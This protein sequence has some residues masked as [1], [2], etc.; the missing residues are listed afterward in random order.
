MERQ[1]A[2]WKTVHTIEGENDLV[3]QIQR[4]GDYKPRYSFKIGRY[5][6]GR[7]GDRYVGAYAPVWINAVE[8]IVADRTP[9]KLAA[10]AVDWIEGDAAQYADNYLAKREYDDDTG[11]R[12]TKHTGKT[13]RDREKKRTNGTR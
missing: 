2:E 6:E 9:V 11:R 5:L 10:M 7:D 3:V 4:L 1:K 8:T 12:T 13:D